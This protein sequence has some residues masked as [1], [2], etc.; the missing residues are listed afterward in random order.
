MEVMIPTLG[1][2][3]QKTYCPFLPICERTGKVLQVP[4]KEIHPE[5]N[6]IVYDDPETGDE[7]ET[8]VLNGKCKLQWK[9]DW[10]MRWFALGVDYEMAGKDLIDSVKLSSRLCRI[11]GGSPPEGIIYELF[12]DE[13]GKK[14]SKSKGNGISMEEWLKYAPHESLAYYMYQTPRRAKRLY[15]DVIPAAMDDYLESLDR[16]HTEP[17]E[18]QIESPVFHIH[19]GNPPRYKGYLKF[20][21]LLNLVQACN[22]ADSTLIMEFIKKYTNKESPDE[23]TVALLEKLAEYAISYYTD[24]VDGTRKPQAPDQKQ[25]EAILALVA[26][27][28]KAGDSRDSEE[29]QGLIFEVGKMFYPEAIKDWFLTLYG[30]LFGTESGPRLGSFISLYGTRNMVN[31]FKERL[32]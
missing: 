32:R 11:F 29:L 24:F 3:R 7:V 18:K 26:K 1:E 25:R 2:D 19:N 4:A 21:M 12:L 30:V 14:I 13:E 10:G 9:A 15:F 20:S 31:L 27:L 16:Y 28:E 5:R 22:T 8:S 23:K 17:P 6:S